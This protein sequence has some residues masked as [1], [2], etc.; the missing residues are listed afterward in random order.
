MFDVLSYWLSIHPS[1][2][3]ANIWTRG[4]G[5]GKMSKAEFLTAIEI[6]Q[7]QN[8]ML[9]LPD[10]SPHSLSL[11]L[12]LSLPLSVLPDSLND[13]REYLYLHSPFE[14]VVWAKFSKTF[15][16]WFLKMSIIETRVLLKKWS[17]I[18]IMKNLGKKTLKKVAG[19]QPLWMAL[20]KPKKLIF[21]TFF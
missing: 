2:R 15:K 8:M 9:F 10:P 21:K 20:V 4:G 7:Y 11:S 3:E 6:F 18:Q 13:L 12:C 19:S 17:I 1:I 14:I 16:I 5:G